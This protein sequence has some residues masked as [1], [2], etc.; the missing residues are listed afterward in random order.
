MSNLSWTKTYSARV[1]H[2]L[3]H[4]SC[5]WQNNFHHRLGLSWV[6]RME[7]RLW[8]ALSKGFLNLT[9]MAWEWAKIQPCF[10]TVVCVSGPSEV[11]VPLPPLPCSHTKLKHCN[12]RNVCNAAVWD[13]V[14]PPKMTLCNFLGRPENALTWFF[15]DLLRLILNEVVATL[16]FLTGEHVIQTA[17][18]R[19][20]WHIS[21]SLELF[22]L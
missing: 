17:T 1:S 20:K 4:F 21:Q 14:H 18:L 15:W 13:S 12:I 19:R 9:V 7:R 22:E 8:W 6:L 3:R 5:K 10:T 2:V 11:L 16:A